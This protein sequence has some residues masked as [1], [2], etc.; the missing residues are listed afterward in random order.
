MFSR[1]L[2]AASLAALVAAPAA[3][4]DLT[5]DAEA[6]EQLF[7][8]QCVT[9]HVVVNDAGETLA[10]RNARTGPNLYAVTNRTAGTVEDFRYSNG[11]EA[12]NE[13]G[14]EWTEENF[15]GYVQDPTG[16]LREATD[17]NR[18]RGKMTWR[19]RSEE[20]AYDLYAYLAS[21][22]PAADDMEGDSEESG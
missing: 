18:V 2:A 12:A 21:L 15:V 8:R 9:C 3:A 5:G 4:Q 11:L 16:W 7:D 14:V 13:M 6:G 22:A 17:N 19:V 20:E 10:G 1:Q